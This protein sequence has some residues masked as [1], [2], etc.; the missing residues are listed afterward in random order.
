MYHLFMLI[1]DK[2]NNGKNLV[3]G[4]YKEQDKH[5]DDSIDVFIL[6]NTKNA[7]R[8]RIMKIISKLKYRKIVVLCTS[9]DMTDDENNETRMLP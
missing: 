3:C 5:C 9:C 7:I 8:T 2:L 4:E 6:F 1:L